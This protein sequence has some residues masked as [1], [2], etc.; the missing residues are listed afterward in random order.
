MVVQNSNLLT[1][2]VYELS[3]WQ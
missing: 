1:A 3:C 2:A